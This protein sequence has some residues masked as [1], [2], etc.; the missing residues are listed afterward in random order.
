MTPVVL[1]AAAA[2]AAAILAGSSG[3]N[4]YQTYQLSSYLDA[5]RRGTLPRPPSSPPSATLAEYLPPAAAAGYRRPLVALAPPEKSVDDVLRDLRSMSR[6]EL[7]NLFL[8]CPA[9]RDAAAAAGEWDGTLLDNGGI[10]MSS[11]SALLTDAAFGRGRSW[12]GKSIGV[13][14]SGV[15]DVGGINRFRPRRPEED[16][17]AA[18]GTEAEHR[19]DCSVR[20]SRIDPG[21]ES[22]LLEYRDYQGALSPWRGMRDELRVLRLSDGRRKRGG[23]G[24]VLI[25]MGCMDWSGAFW[26]DGFMNCAP[27]CLY[28]RD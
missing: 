4:M 24:S 12:A 17:A 22:L 15:R 27:F 11:A 19:F 20:P 3:L 14:G 28:I 18:E 9:P 25:G 1:Q 10:V 13:R 8:R 26:R 5:D 7:L 16:R 2:A 21:S 6:S 23:G